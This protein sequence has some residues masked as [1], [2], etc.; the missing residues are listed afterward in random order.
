MEKGNSKNS[1]RRPVSV[2]NTPYV[3]YAT[4]SKDFAEFII[5]NNCKIKESE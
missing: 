3:D 1:A 2:D 5:K 4:K